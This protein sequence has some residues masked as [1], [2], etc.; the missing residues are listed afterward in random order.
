MTTQEDVKIVV[1]AEDRASTVLNRIAAA[2]GKADAQVTAMGKSAKS[3]AAGVGGLA[4]LL[5][6][7]WMANF[8]G[9][10]KQATNVVKDLSESL[11]GGGASAAIFKAGIAAIVVTVSYKVGQMIENWIFQTDAWRRKLKATLDEAK[12]AADGVLSKQNRQHETRMAMN[13]AEIN[14]ADAKAANKEYLAELDKDV[15]ARQAKVDEL[16][17]EQEQWKNGW[18]GEDS[19]IG[20]WNEDMTSAVE[21]ELEIEKK[22][23]DAAKQRR[24]EVQHE[25]SGIKEELDAKKARQAEAKAAAEEEKRIRDEVAR[26]KDPKAAEMEQALA[27]TTNEI[28]RE[29][30]RLLMEEKQAIEA[31]REAEKL[32][33]EEAKENARREEEEARMRAQSIKEAWDMWREQGKAKRDAA[34]K[35]KEDDQSYLDDLKQ[36]MIELKQGKDAAEEFKAAKDGV[37]QAAIDQ[38]KA[39]RAEINKLEEEKKKKEQADKKADKP[40]WQVSSLNALESRVLAGRSAGMNYAA[41][42]ATNTQKTVAAVERHA[43]L[44]NAMLGELKIIARK[45]PTIGVVGGA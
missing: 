6:V 7:D 24:S 35:Q 28:E 37:S 32:A 36:Q 20:N 39:M 38:G 31:K 34:K 33:A 13:A 26:L 12:D 44:A 3:A 30:I 2:A 14:P 5:G 29:R 16:K 21:A 22:L 11:K 1:S 23:L 41:M 45:P 10:A 27:V 42:T 18:L 15:K 9:Q 4:S 19:Y 17:K 8:A 43:E 40:G 25:V